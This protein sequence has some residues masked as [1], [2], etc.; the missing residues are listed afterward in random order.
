MARPG[1]RTMAEAV[2][3]ADAGLDSHREE[4]MRSLSTTLARLE[5]AC[6]E[7]DEAAE[8]VVYELASAFADMA[9]FF[10]TGPLYAAAFSLCETSDRMTAGGCW[11]WPSVHVHVRAL[12]LILAADCRP[13]ETSRV[14]LEGL[15]SI[16]ARLPR[17]PG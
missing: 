15:A 5:A 16:V 14:L 13:T 6:I 7:Q 3:A 1:G 2:R 4:G 10:D 17:P 12:R 11:Q 8:A 9:G